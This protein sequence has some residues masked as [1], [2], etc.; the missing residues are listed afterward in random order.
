MERDGDEKIGVL[1]QRPVPRQARIGEPG[2]RTAERS[3]LPVLK[4]Q[5]DV[6]EHAPVDAAGPVHRISRGLGQAPGAGMVPARAFVESP[7][8]GADR[9]DA[10]G[11]LR[12]AGAADD[13]LP[14]AFKGLPADVAKGG[15]N[16]KPGEPGQCGGTGPN[17]KGHWAL[18]SSSVFSWQSIQ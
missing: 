8:A 9:P 6:L 5:D 15:E 14:C 13:L 2:Q 7:A 17:R 4:E 11:E 10:R 18:S 3:V 12:Q 1:P 16:E